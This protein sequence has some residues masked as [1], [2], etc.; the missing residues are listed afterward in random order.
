M[1]LGQANAQWEFKVNSIEKSIEAIGKIKF[2]IQLKDSIILNLSKSRRLGLDFSIKGKYFKPEE[3]YYVLFEILDRKIKA[4]NSITEKNSFRI[5]E[6]KDLISSEKYELEDFLNILK[7]GKKCI[8]TIRSSTRVI[9]GY[10]ILTGSGMAINSV[11]KA[12]I[13]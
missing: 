1:I 12:G 8:I 10:N 5:F 13:P 2:N 6:V 7:K 11:L 9:Q 3:E 4:S